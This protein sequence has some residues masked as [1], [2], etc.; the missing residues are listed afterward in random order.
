MKPCPFCWPLVK[1]EAIAVGEHCVTVPSVD[2]ILAGSCM[3]VP[4][5]HRETVFDLTEEEW[6]DTYRLLAEAKARIDREWSPDGYNVGW[7]CMPVGGQTVPHAHLHVIPRFRDEPL[8][9][10]GIR[11]HLKQPSNRR[12]AGPAAKSDAG[13]R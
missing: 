7:N 12:T 4:K 10:K 13:E 5:A 6:A 9:G 2:P 11:H 3:I 8:A 1:R